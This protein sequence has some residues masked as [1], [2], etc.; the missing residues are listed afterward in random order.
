MDGGSSRLAIRTDVV[1]DSELVQGFAAASAQG[2]PRPQ[3]EAF[4]NYW[5]PFGDMVTNVLEG[6]EEPAAAVEAAC[7]AMNDANGKDAADAIIEESA[8]P[9][10]E[11][12][13]EEAAAEEAES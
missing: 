9:A 6:V 13:V 11:A 4:G 10:E 7:A 12:P 8:A 5:G 1:A 2:F 3:S